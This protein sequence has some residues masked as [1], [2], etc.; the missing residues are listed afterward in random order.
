MELRWNTID[1]SKQDNV[2]PILCWSV[3]PLRPSINFRSMHTACRLLRW[4]CLIHHVRKRTPQGTCVMEPRP[5]IRP[6]QTEG[7]PGTFAGHPLSSH[8]RKA[9]QG[10]GP[11][12]AG[13]P[14]AL[15]SPST[16]VEV[17][18]VSSVAH[19]MKGTNEVPTTKEKD[20]MCAVQ[21][22]FPARTDMRMFL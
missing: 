1:C 18:Q 6:F 10:A 14:P 21:I 3:A 19:G 12:L 9:R 22:E 11:T 20:F 17:T 4:K 7:R 5:P 2:A 13:E 8:T 16:V 15:R